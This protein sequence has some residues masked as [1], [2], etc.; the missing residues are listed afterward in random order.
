MEPGK[1]S[2][3]NFLETLHFDLK[4]TQSLDLRASSLPS[5]AVAVLKAAHTEFI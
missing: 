2:G 4:F 3:Q 5:G 1:V